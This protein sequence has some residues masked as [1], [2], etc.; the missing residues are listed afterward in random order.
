MNYKPIW[1]AGIAMAL[2]GTSAPAQAQDYR[3][4]QYGIHGPELRVI[5]GDGA[6]PSAMIDGKAMAMTA[7]AE[8]D[9]DYPIRVCSLPIPAGSMSIAVGGESLPPLPAEPKR[10][11]VIGDTGCRIE[12][13]KLQNCND[14]H[15]WPF[16]QIAERG[17]AMKPDLII[18]VGDYLYRETACPTAGCSGSPFGDNWAAFNTDFFAPAKHL[19]TAAPWVFV[20]G[21]HEICERGGKGWMHML[22]PRPFD[23]AAGCLGQAEPFDVR[24]GSL[25]LAV[26]DVSSAA[27]DNVDQADAALFA[28]RFQALASAPED[29][30]LLLHRPIWGVAKLKKKGVAVGFNATLGAAAGGQLPENV[31]LMLAGHVH[32]FQVLNYEAGLP[33]QMIVGQGGDDLDHDAP[34]DLTGVNVNGESVKS[35]FSMPEMF[36]FVLMEKRADGWATTTYDA[37]GNIK[38]TCRIADRMIACD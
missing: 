20:R 2:T 7:R 3:W 26:F 36:G 27:E 11:L 34:P 13:K 8:P 19:L 18:D 30:W 25:S 33:P 24:I 15:D 21:N 9:S 17:A 29:T 23:A 31:S 28:K 14:A 12:G 22:D 37:S 16:P 1:A 38:R 32:T 5:S 4:I 6:C 10:I 35:G